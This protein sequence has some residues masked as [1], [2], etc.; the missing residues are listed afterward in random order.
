M[1]PFMLQP[2]ALEMAVLPQGVSVMIAASVCGH[3]LLVSSPGRDSHD[4]RSSRLA[5]ATQKALG[6]NAL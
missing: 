4:L 5:E 3:C 6:T 2:L 1:D